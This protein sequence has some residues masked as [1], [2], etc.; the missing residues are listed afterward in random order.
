M[1]RNSGEALTDGEILGPGK[2]EL[3]YELGH[4]WRQGNW[5]WLLL[6]DAM[7]DSEL[8]LDCASDTFYYTI[9]PI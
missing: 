6:F 3:E 8:L 5:D 1:L 2:G 7:F 4:L 9:S